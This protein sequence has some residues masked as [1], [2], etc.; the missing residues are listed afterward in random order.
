MGP[1]WVYQQ[2]QCE[3]YMEINASA[4]SFFL[5]IYVI[6]VIPSCGKNDLFTESSVKQSLKNDVCLIELRKWAVERLFKYD[7]S[8]VNLLP[9]GPG[10]RGWIVEGMTIKI[11]VEPF[12]DIECFVS[13]IGRDLKKP[14][15]FFLSNKSRFG[16]L[17][18]RDNCYV[19]HSG[20]LEIIGS[21]I[22]LYSAY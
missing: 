22:A 10:P 6:F 21:G 13:L 5:S 2:R 19:L 11:P 16:L 3:D 18:S 12:S 4:L 17:I 20:K 14:D 1:T 8:K 7:W 15:C 9:S